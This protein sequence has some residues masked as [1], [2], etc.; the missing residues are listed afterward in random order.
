MM[1]RREDWGRAA[2]R[3]GLPTYRP[4]LIAGLTIAAMS[5]APL[6]GGGEAKADQTFTVTTDAA[7]GAGSLAA[8]IAQSN[9]TGGNNTIVF[10]L[11]AGNATIDASALPVITSNIVVNGANIGGGGQITVNGNGNRPFFLGDGGT[12]TPAAP[13]AVTLENLAI[14]G[15]T[16][17]GGAGGGAALEAGGA[18]AGLGGAVFVS[19]NASLT[20]GNVSLTSNRAVGGQGGASNGFS[21]E[22]GGGGLGGNGGTGASGNAGGG[23]F[24]VGANGANYNSGSANGSAGSLPGAGSGGSGSGAV[25]GT[26]GANAGGGGS[27]GTAG[28][29][30]GVNGQNGVF[31]QGGNGG[32]GGGGG[33]GGP[34]GTGGYGGGGLGGAIFVQAGGTVTLTGALTID[35]TNTAAG[36]AGGAGYLGGTGL[37][38]KGFGSAIFYQGTQGTTSTLSFGAGAQSISAVMADYVGSGGTNPNGGANAN[39]QGGSL[40]IAKSGTGTLTLGGAN[41]YSGGTSVNAGTLQLSGAGT[42][43]AATATTKIAGGTL[44]LG[45]TTQTQAAV[46]LAGGTLQNG[47]INAAISSTGGT[48]NGIGGAASVTASAG[49]TIVAGTNAY[50]GATTVNGGTLQVDGAITGTSGVAVNSGATLTG[51]GTIDPL[52]VAIN[53]GATFAPGN[54][55]PGTSTAIIGNL[56]FQSGALYVVQIN[57]AASSFATITG[58][59]T[60]SGATINA[61]FAAGSYVSKQYT[62]L[63]A[64]GGVVGAFGAL[65]N[66]NLPSGFKSTLSY[67]AGDAYLN[68]ALALPTPSFGGGLSTNQQNV[69]NALVNFFNNSGSIPLAFGA[70]TPAGLTQLSGELATGAQQTTFDA[71]NLFMG[72][73]TDPFVGGRGDNATS[74]GNATGYADADALGYAGKRKPDDALAA[75][76]RKAPPP[77]VPFQQQWSVWAA[78]YGGSQTTDGNTALGSNSATSRVFGTAVGADYRFSPFTVA[79]FALAG[80]GTNFSVANSGSGRSDLFQAGG[81]IRHTM[82][83][84]YLG[85]A[86]AYG[87]QDITTDRNVIVAGSDQ[88]HANFDANA[89]SGRVEGGY[90]YVTPFM[91]DIG[92]TPYA[93][94]QVTAFVLPTYAE[95]ALAGASTFALDYNSKSVTDTRSEL[96][97]RTDKS[98]AMEAGILTLRS[99]TAW[100]YDFNPDR[101]IAATF[102]ALPGASFVVNGAAQA[103]DGLLS[104]SSLEF[105]WMNGWSAAA[106]FEGEF[107]DVTRSY[108]GKGVVRYAW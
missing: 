9:S 69:G 84:A 64:T 88:L 34:G 97:L 28:G 87:W 54:G 47:T 37:N 101:S 94:A 18:G 59:A 96:G 44:D 65:V 29:G 67:D 49:T 79:G 26:G 93:A 25:A 78:G 52:V 13:F 43:G 108:A 45:G 27:G 68:L 92:L 38:G 104:S 105:K 95:T 70:L 12:T 3:R 55:T 77:T 31:G 42:L 102:Q 76:Y 63:S 24:G 57:P 50:T 5:V 8:A 36:G 32:F 11:S 74:S 83:N 15:S 41:T 62:I 107:S 91:G 7:S 100:A 53:N 30:G 66:T 106:T 14:T 20:I 58:S 46:N 56:A 10:N 103:R 48:I 51:T 72:V 71:M 39:D 98:Y 23:G 40:A 73:L 19:A 35:G 22:S 82:G 1:R 33:A 17:Q 80:G 81:F 61:M 21:G 75:I 6:F 4:R 89:F 86:L 60:L 90:R 99:R 16:A 2:V 85:G